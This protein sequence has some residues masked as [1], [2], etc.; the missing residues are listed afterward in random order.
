MKYRVDL[1]YRNKYMKQASE[2]LKKCDMDIG[3]VGI[4]ETFT[5]SSQKCPTIE[6]VKE[7]VLKSFDGS[8]LEILDIT[9]WIS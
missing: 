5:F 6:K 2:F 7:E 9:V 3:D 1:V 4:K 8:D